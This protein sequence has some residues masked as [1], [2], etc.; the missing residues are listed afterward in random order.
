MTDILKI[1]QS[2]LSRIES[3]RRRLQ[4]DEARKL[5]KVWNT[6]RMFELLVWYA[7]MGHDPQWFAQYIEKECRAGIIRIFE[8][9]LAHGLLQTE[10]YARALIMAGSSTEPEKI[11]RE[12]VMRQQMFERLPPP[13]VT[14]LISQN[15]IE[16]P[17]GS[18]EIMR[19]QLQHLLDLSELPH[20]I[21]RV[22]PRTYEV[23]A[24]PGLNGSFQL[25]AGEDFGEVCYTE[26]SGGGRLVSTPSEVLGFAAR[27]DQI[28]A[29]AL[30][31]GPSR[32]LIRSL[33]EAVQ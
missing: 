4:G 5:D 13:Q 33:M 30:M 21:V 14:C 3:G 25:M 17:V 28:S 8:S 26:S 24:Y 1:S 22:V 10:D 31:E 9:Q 6:G 11:L 27:F 19:G 32:D 15:A 16:W 2:T 29:K 20:V 18:P 7:S 23:G 12:R